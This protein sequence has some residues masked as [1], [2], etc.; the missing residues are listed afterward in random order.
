MKSS[1]NLINILV[2]GGLTLSLVIFGLRISETSSVEAQA[3]GGGIAALLDATGGI[4]QRFELWPKTAIIPSVYPG[5]NQN[6]ALIGQGQTVFRNYGTAILD[7][8]IAYNTAYFNDL[9]VGFSSFP[10]TGGGGYSSKSIDDGVKLFV[11]GKIQIKAFAATG[12]APYRKVCVN[13]FGLLVIDCNH[14]GFNA[15]GTL[16]GGSGGGGEPGGPIFGR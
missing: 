2:L 11:D 15:N 16:Y 10:T 1:K 7:D 12:G 14:P 3:T 5:L 6:A 9:Y 8:L 4:V 13:D